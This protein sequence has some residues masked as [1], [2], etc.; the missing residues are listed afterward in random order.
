MRIF[1]TVSYFDFNSHVLWGVK[2]I[3]GW[4]ISAGELLWP[5]ELADCLCRCK[6][7]SNSREDFPWWLRSFPANHKTALIKSEQCVFLHVCIWT[8][9][10]KCRIEFSLIT[11]LFSNIPFIF[12]TPSKSTSTC[13]PRFFFLFFISVLGYTQDK[14]IAEKQNEIEEFLILVHN[15]IYTSVAHKQIN[16][17][18]SSLKHRYIEDF[19]YFKT[20]KFPWN[21]PSIIF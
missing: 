19:F 17:T 18:L 11:T 1:L 2:M 21:W 4:L 3:T 12:P 7:C 16:T 20:S 10:G 13:N 5:H 14:W 8:F 9:L 6:H 15:F